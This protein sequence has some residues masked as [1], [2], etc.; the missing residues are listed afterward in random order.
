MLAGICGGH[1]LQA[2][3]LSQLPEQ[4]PAGCFPTYKRAGGDARCAH[5][6]VVGDFIDEVFG[7][8]GGV[9]VQD[10]DP[11]QALQLAEAAQQLRQALA[12][13]PAHPRRMVSLSLSF[14]ISQ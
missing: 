9:S 6:G 8:I 13:S 14:E 12:V 11:V 10:T 5:L 7:E 1:L 2:F 3:S 4:L